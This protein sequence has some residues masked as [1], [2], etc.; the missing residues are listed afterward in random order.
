VGS[1]KRGDC[2]EDLDVVHFADLEEIFDGLKPGDLI[3]IS[4]P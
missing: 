2:L 4:P 3:L 1:E